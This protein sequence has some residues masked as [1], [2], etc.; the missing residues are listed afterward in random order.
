MSD[1]DEIRRVNTRVKL[2]GIESLN[3]HDRW[4][5]D[6]GQADQKC[7]QERQRE[8][9]EREAERARA[10]RANDIEARIT[11]LEG[12]MDQIERQVSELSRA[13]GDFSDAVNAGF[14]SLDEQLKKLSTLLTSLRA[15]DDQH[16]AVLDL[17]NPLIRRVN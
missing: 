1:A 8:A 4:R 16:R 2:F 10:V 3:A 13:V 12:R 15:A 7:A 11:A 6:N 5:Y 9:K 14:L 17:P